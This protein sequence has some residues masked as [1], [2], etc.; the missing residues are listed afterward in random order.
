MKTRILVL[1]LSLIPILA[2]AQNAGFTRKKKQTTTVATPK[3]QDKPKQTAKTAEPKKPKEQPKQQAEKTKQKHSSHRTN[4]NNQQYRNTYQEEDDEDYY[5]EP[6]TGNIRVTSTPSGATI[7]IDGEKQYYTTPNTFY[8]MSLGSHTVKVEANGDF[9][10]MV[11]E[12]MVS[13]DETTYVDF[14]LQSKQATLSISTQNDASVYIDNQEVGKGSV[15]KTLS[16]G[17]HTIKAMLK[18]HRTKTVDVNIVGGQ[19][20][21]LDLRLAPLYGTL[22]IDANRPYTEI[23]VDGKKYSSSLT[24]VENLL[25]GEHTLSLTGGR[26]VYSGNFTIRENEVTTVAANLDLK[27]VMLDLTSS[28]YLY[29]NAEVMLN[30]N[31]RMAYP[32][33]KQLPAGDYSITVKQKGYKKYSSTISLD[34]DM[35]YKVYMTK[36]KNS[37]HFFF[38]YNYTTVAPIGAYLGMTHGMM[39][40]YLDGSYSPVSSPDAKGPTEWGDVN[41]SSMQHKGKQ[42]MAAHAGP[43]LHF[44]P[45]MIFVGGGYGKYASVWENTS[46]SQ[47]YKTYDLKGL[48]VQAGV[49]LHFGP[50]NI[51]AGYTKMFSDEKFSDINVGAGLYF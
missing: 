31:I 5:Y 15:Q 34:N 40:W 49:M 26:Y 17:K 1:L 29:N 33:K 3:Q 50:V 8:D 18:S 39:G 6:P 2:L 37:N 36:K 16:E 30:N 45:V 35:V 25:V 48:E 27:Q 14:A 4:T 38:G 24:R 46:N 9:K 12:V 19:N 13:E 23:L 44:S 51:R 41:I 32:F 42:R 21:Q 22:K 7:Y 28:S 11:K 43:M 47:C 20:Q 10:P